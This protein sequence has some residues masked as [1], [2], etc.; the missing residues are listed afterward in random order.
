LDIYARGIPDEGRDRGL[1]RVPEDETSSIRHWVN[2]RGRYPFDDKQW[3]DVVFNQQ[4]DAGVQSEFFQSEYQRFEE[5]DSYVHWR[6]ARDG[7][8]FNGRVQIQQDDFRTEVER[9]PSFGAYRGLAELF[10][11]GSLPVNYRASADAEYLTRREGDLRFERDFLDST[12]APDGLGE[13]STMRGDT[14]HRIE[15][16]IPIGIPGT[17]VTPFVDARFTAWSK[18]VDPADDPSRLAVFGGARLQSI[19]TRAAGAAYHTLI[20][21]VEVASELSLE[22]NGGNVVGFD[23]V[24]D[25]QDGDR[26]EV[27][28]RSLWH[29]PDKEH[30]LDFDASI[31]QRLNREGGLPDTEQLRFLGGARSS[32]G[33]VPVGLEH[34]FRQELDGNRTLYSRTIIAVQPTED[35]LMQ[36]GH[37][38]AWENAGGG[39]FETASLDMRYR[40]SRK[41]ELGVT[42]YTNIQDGGSLASEFTLRRFSHDFVLELEVTRYAGEGGTGI[43]LNFMPLLAWKPKTL[44]ILD[45]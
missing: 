28:I 25:A 29:R 15:I 40:I 31:S 37:Q 23:S 14:S 35:L 11:I 6:K 18:G 33:S 7:H 41:W 30:W 17:A 39:I 26:V 16:P 2:V 21:R 38:H 24:E 10:R 22:Q 34:D 32:F 43:G 19:F 45:R 9:K 5:R 36:L 27:G 20:P 42:N 12:G 4:G 8:F 3:I 1:L 13:R 44:G